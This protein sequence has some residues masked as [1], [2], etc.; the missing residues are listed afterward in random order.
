MT[1]LRRLQ[2][3]LW[4][5]SIFRRILDLANWLYDGVKVEAAELEKALE[6][7]RH[8]MWTFERPTAFA[9]THDNIRDL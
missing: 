1:I 8:R 3:R 6:G 4:S 7:R 2:G 9:Y 5:L